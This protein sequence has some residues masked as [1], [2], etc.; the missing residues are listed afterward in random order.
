MKTTLAGMTLTVTALAMA[1][2]VL[3]A[4]T[5]EDNSNYLAWG[6]L[7]LCGLIVFFQ[8]VPVIS[9]VSNL[10][11]SLNGTEDAEMEVVESK[12]R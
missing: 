6:F 2:P 11:K 12:Y 8:V 7:A 5:R 10:I 9:I 3:A 4:A 1:T